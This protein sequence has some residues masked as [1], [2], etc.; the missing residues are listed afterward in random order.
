MTGARP[1]GSPAPTTSGSERADLATRPQAG[2]LV[3]G[4]ADVAALEA[5][6]FA[7]RTAKEK[8]LPPAVRIGVLGDSIEAALLLPDLL[9]WVELLGEPRVGRDAAGNLIVHASTSGDGGGAQRWTLRP[10]VERCPAVDAAGVSVSTT[11]QVERVRHL[12]ARPPAKFHPQ[13]TVIADRSS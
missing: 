5:A 6:L 9:L 8:G 10:V 13:G 11:A 4:G 3:A 2:E 1:G 7:A 12:A